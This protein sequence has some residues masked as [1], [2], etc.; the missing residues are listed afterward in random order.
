MN[1]STESSP[2]G[3]NGA[4]HTRSRLSWNAEERTQLLKLK[5][6][7]CTYKQ[8]AAR[9]D[10]SEDWVGHLIRHARLHERGV[11]TKA[12]SGLSGLDARIQRVLAKQGL[13]SAKDIANAFQCGKVALASGLGEKSLEMIKVWLSR[14]APEHKLH[15]VPKV[16]KDNE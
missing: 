11:L 2:R 7:G 12:P 1:Q 8:L 5:Q 15:L 14:Q 4:E 3:R 10:I 13:V 16:H 9:Y 6:D